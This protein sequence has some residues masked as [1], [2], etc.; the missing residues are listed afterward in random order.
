M[1]EKN[2]VGQTVWLSGGTGFKVSWLAEWLCMMGAKVRIF[3]LPPPTEPALFDQLGLASRVD[4]Q[5]G[6]IREA[7]AV[8]TCLRDKAELDGLWQSGIAHLKVWR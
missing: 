8:S 2:F 6:D 4:W 5:E 7:A 3:S 1:F